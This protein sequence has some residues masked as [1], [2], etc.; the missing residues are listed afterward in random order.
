MKWHDLLGAV[1]VDF[2][3]GTP[4]A[5]D[6][7]IDLSVKKQFLDI[8]VVRK[9]KGELDR[10]LPDGLAPLV[11]HNLIGF[12]SH[13]DVFDGWAL[14]ELI[15][16][17]VNYRKTVS[18]DQD[19]LLP[20]A[21]FRLFGITAH[22]PEKLAKEMAMEEKGPG[23]YD[24]VC[25]PIRIR[26]LVIRNLENRP[27][28]AILELFSLVPDQI[29][30]ACR[31]YRPYSRHTTSIVENRIRKYREEDT[32]MAT[33]LEDIHRKIIR[34]TPIKQRLEGLTPKEIMEVVPFGEFVKDLPPEEIE[35]YLRKANKVKAKKRPRR[36]P[37]E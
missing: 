17:Y 10:T 24:V 1:L 3:D 5:V 22:F 30:Y 13:Q 21:D 29:Q 32:K 9:T 31:S 20:E 35:K 25:G 12:K 33:T 36:G 28:N 2:F 4:Y 8:I 15:G 16:H 27:A 6:T 14:M 37:Q 34:E 18:P 23:V 19:N 26:L 7:E 11:K